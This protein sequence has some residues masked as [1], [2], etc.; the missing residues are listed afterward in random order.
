MSLPSLNPEKTASGIIVDPR[1]LERV[2]PQSRRKDGTV[3]KEQKVR[4]G[5]TPQEDVGRFRSTRQTQEDARSS[6]RP[7]IPGSN[8]IGAQPKVSTENVNVFAS[9]PKEKTKAQIKNEK[10]R[11]KRREKVSMSWDD[12]DGNEDQDGDL[13]EDFK[14]V[15]KAAKQQNQGKDNDNG[16]GAEQS[17]PPFEGSGGTPQE[18]IVDEIKNREDEE[19]GKGPGSSA[20]NIT[21]ATTQ[22]PPPAPSGS[23][24]ETALENRNQTPGNNDN[25]NSKPSLLDDRKAEV[26]QQAQAQSHPIQ[27]GRKGPIGLANPPPIEEARPA[28]STSTSTSKADSTDD[29][30]T[31]QKPQRKGQ[32]GTGSGG[33]GGAGGRGGGGGGGRGGKAQTSGANRQSQ[34]QSQS[35]PAQPSTQAPAA[36]PRE[37]K[38]HKIRE[39]GA[40]DIS[41]LA[42]RVRNLVVANTVGNSKEKKEE[43]A[44]NKGSAQAA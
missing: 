27:G 21:T 44:S 37:R 6:S 18:S 23:A 24:P 42:S 15:D 34:S 13:G 28:T 3:R 11:E 25:N 10:R 8:K 14:E 17:F 32:Q 26:K 33:R 35:K 40:N 1:T 31:V 5:F 19:D 4:P 38:E 43:P 9:D 30:R 29:W 7:I 12:E 39:G 16:K 36:P 41:S 20:E 2:I 22:N